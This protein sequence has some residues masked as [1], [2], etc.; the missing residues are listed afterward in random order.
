MSFDTFIDLRANQHNNQGNEG[1]WP[2]FTDIMTTIVMIFLIALVV[3]LARN[4]E[5]VQQLRSTMEA[6]RIASEL[7]HVTGEQKDLLATA[8]HAAESNLQAL[9]GQ[10]RDLDARDRSRLARITAQQST[11]FDLQQSHEQ[12][13]GE[14]AALL[15]LREQLQSEVAQ[16]KAQLRRSALAVQQRE[17]ALQMAQQARNSLQ[18][19]LQVSEDNVAEAEQRNL[20]L[21]AELAAQQQVLLVSQEDAEA[22]AQRYANLVADYANLKTKYDKLIR[23]ARTARGRYR[24]EVRYW[25]RDGEYRI[26]WREGTAGRFQSVSREQ[27]DAIL[28]RLDQQQDQGLYIRVVLPDDSDLSHSE[29]WQFTLYLH[30]RYDYYFKK[31]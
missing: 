9:R 31:P 20:Q 5:L 29:A 18:A 1:F 28:T 12:L 30:Q 19:D 10:V 22:V 15:L 27:L 7:A 24:V 6:E 21:S 25:K 23:P 3:L 4:L 14:T 8:L 11:I 17:V 26:A 13:A 16:Q 2:S